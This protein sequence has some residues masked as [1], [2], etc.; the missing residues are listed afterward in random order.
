MLG[1]IAVS[2]IRYFASIFAWFFLN[3]FGLWQGMAQ[4]LGQVVAVTRAVVF[5]RAKSEEHIALSLPF[6]GY[7]TVGKGGVTKTTSHSWRVIAQR[8][9]Y[10]FYVTDDDGKSHQGNGERLEDYYAFGK[11][12]LAPADGIVV[13]VQNGIRDYPN[14]GKGWIDWRARDMRGNYVVI[15]HG[16]RA[17]T[18]IAHRSSKQRSPVCC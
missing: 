9:A 10:D 7:W 13:E 8:Y 2:Y 18:V 15:R 14:P 6:G 5:N 17:Y 4:V 12:V 1:S 16:E 3:P 11:A